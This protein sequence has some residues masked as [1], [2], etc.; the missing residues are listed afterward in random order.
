MEVCCFKANTKV[1]VCN[2]RT[3]TQ[4]RPISLLSTVG[5][6]FSGVL[7]NRLTAFADAN[8]LI[9]DEQNGFRINRSC[10]DHLHSLTS[11]IRNRKRKG[12]STFV[13]FIDMENVFDKIDRNLLFYRLLL[14]NKNEKMCKAIRSLYTDCKCS[15]NINGF[16]TDTF[17][18]NAG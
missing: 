11:L 6:L 14:I 7:D 1:K 2:P 10:I 8:G 4:Y 12:Q 18:Y 5:E 17:S 15:I 3:P 9:C 13:C 16:L